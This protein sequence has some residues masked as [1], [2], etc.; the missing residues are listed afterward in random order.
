MRILVGIAMTAMAG[1]TWAGPKV[2][3]CMRLGPNAPALIMAQKLASK[4][5]ANI[6]VQTDWPEQLNRSDSC[7][8]NADAVVT[9][10]Y[11]TSRADHPRAWAYALPY[12]GKHIVVFWDR[13]QHKVPP[14]HAPFL[15][16][17]VLVHEITHILQGIN[18]H[19]ESGV[20]KAG[21][22]ADDIYKM[23]SGKPLG[24]TELDVE[25]IHLGLQARS[26]G[27]V[28]APG[29]AAINPEKY[30]PCYRFSS[31]DSHA[32][33]NS[34]SRITVRSEMPMA[35]TVCSTLRPPK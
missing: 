34:Q 25:L 3:V 31:R 24:F 6:G 9:L 11:N 16:A 23:W 19:S 35:S 2:T 1:C 13:V 10:S 28:D 18:R 17:Y 15:L 5:F 21:W 14:E 8:A 29:V 22:D 26:V 30:R 32:L 7:P 20:M 33:A 4:I 27:A 12:E